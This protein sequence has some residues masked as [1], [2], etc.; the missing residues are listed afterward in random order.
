MKNRCTFRLSVRTV[1]VLVISAVFSL[2]GCTSEPEKG[3]LEEAMKTADTVDTKLVTLHP[4]LDAPI[5]RGDS[6]LIHLIALKDE[7]LLLEGDMTRL[8]GGFVRNHGGL[9]NPDSVLRGMTY[10]QLIDRALLL[11]LSTE[12]GYNP[13]D[14]KGCTDSILIFLPGTDA[15]IPGL[16]PTEAA[17]LRDQLTQLGEAH[18]SGL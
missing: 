9:E 17:R 4:I 6:L 14:C 7:G 10:R 8:V 16:D 18:A 2:S 12:Y 15:R 3:E 11:D 1:A 5:H 13:A